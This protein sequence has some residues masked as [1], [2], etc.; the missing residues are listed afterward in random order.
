MLEGE[1]IP[2]VSI[3]INTYNHEQFI[4]S[5][6]K[7]ALM[8]QTDFSFE[9]L[10]G[11]DDSDDGTREIC[12][13]YA[14]EYPDKI[15]LFLRSRKDVIYINGNPTGRF[16]FIE[17]IKNAR[18]KYIALLP[19]DDYWTD[20]LKL[21]KQVDALEA[22]PGC[23]CCHHWHRVTEM[24]KDG[25]YVEAEA[26]RKGF[27]YFPQ[28]VATARDIFANRL[29]IKARTA[30][31]RNV[32]KDGFHFPDWFLT[33]AFGDVP[34]SMI[35]G[36]MG[37]FFFI[38][39]EMAVYR[40]TGAGVST[41]GKEEFNFYFNHYK[42]WIEI[43]ELGDLLYKGK[44]RDEAVRTIVEFYKLILIRYNYDSQIFRKALALAGKESRLPFLLR[45]KIKAKL[46]AA[47][48]EGR[49]S[50]G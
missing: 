11:E 18:G 25:V 28:Q 39:E 9:I 22:N 17:N 30:M 8:Q 46:R 38:D 31:Y 43:W 41:K 44:Y 32:F 3:I 26:P 40:L 48:R 29:R 2:V 36:T 15:R 20:P 10:I 45:L 14:N 35:M 19:G 49:Q 13:R 27:G 33:V 47:Y 50:A 7:S 4:E 42:S 16:N 12:I 34:L 24:N 37:N 6:I 21:Q 1:T 5:A 23:I